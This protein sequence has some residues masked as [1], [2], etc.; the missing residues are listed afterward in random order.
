MSY[1]CRFAGKYSKQSLL[2]LSPQCPLNSVIDN[3]QQNPFEWVSCSRKPF[4]RA[5]LT[6]LHSDNLGRISLPNWCADCTPEEIIKHLK[7]NFKRINSVEGGPVL[8]VFCCPWI[9]ILQKH[10]GMSK[11]LFNSTEV[12]CVF[13]QG[14]VTQDVLTGYAHGGLP[15]LGRPQVAPRHTLAPIVFWAM[16]VLH[17]LPGNI[18]EHF[19]DPQA[20]WERERIHWGRYVS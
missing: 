3:E 2:Y 12:L 4:C 9:Y 5:L 7:H 17:L 18:D 13:P 14:K 15:A 6:H 10:P 8:I 16:E 20:W 19:T 11:P 1:F